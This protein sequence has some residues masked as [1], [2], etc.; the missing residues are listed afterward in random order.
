LLLLGYED[1]VTTQHVAFQ[2]TER[3]DKR[4]LV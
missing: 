2:S 1:L 4:L 3:G